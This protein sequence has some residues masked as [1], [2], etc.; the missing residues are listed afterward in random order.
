VFAAHPGDFAIR[1]GFPR[2]LRARRRRTEERTP[3]L[4]KYLGNARAVADPYVTGSMMIFTIGF[5]G[6]VALLVA[7]ILY[8]PEAPEPDED[9]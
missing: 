4:T 6:A 8:A 5:A 2:T 3:V 1:C 7:M 9:C